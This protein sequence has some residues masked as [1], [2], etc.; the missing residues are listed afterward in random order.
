MFRIKSIPFIEFETTFFDSAI[1]LFLAI[2]ILAV[3]QI[4]I[5][6]KDKNIC[7]IHDGFSK[8]VLGSAKNK[9]FGL[10]A[11]IIA[12]W[13]AEFAFASIIAISIW[14]YFDQNVNIVP[15]PYNIIGFAGLL[16]FGL[17]IF[18][19]TRPFRRAVYGQGFLQ[20]KISKK[21]PSR[22]HKKKKRFEHEAPRSRRRKRK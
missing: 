11:E 19:H 13:I 3:I 20:S 10:R 1:I 15:F 21:L 12:L 6:K 16:A 5:V 17:L 2:L 7:E 9:I 4:F 22:D 14:I 18:S 8:A